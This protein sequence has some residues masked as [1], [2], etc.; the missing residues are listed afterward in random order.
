MRIY[1]KLKWEKSLNAYG[2]VD[3]GTLRE[4]EHID[5]QSGSL[6]EKVE[7]GNALARTYMDY[8]LGRVMC[9]DTV[10]QLRG[11]R[12]AITDEGML[13]QAMWRVRFAETVWRMRSSAVMRSRC[14]SLVWR[15]RPLACR[16]RFAPETHLAGSFSAESAHA[17]TILCAKHRTAAAGGFSV[18]RGTGGGDQRDRRAGFPSR[19]AVAGSAEAADRRDQRR[20]CGAES[21]A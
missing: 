12:T 9:C 6:A 13:Y 15:R 10:E 1:N 14:V 4:R 19:P 20:D 2:L 3:I 8:L 11:Y 16:P 17:D 18:P 21:S 5:P 7:T